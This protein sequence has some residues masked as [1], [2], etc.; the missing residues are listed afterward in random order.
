M[1]TDRRLILPAITLM[2]SALGGCGRGQ[3]RQVFVQ[4]RRGA[5]V[6]VDTGSGVRV[7]APSS[8]VR[9]PRGRSGSAGRVDVPIVEP[10]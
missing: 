7:K 5:Q 10:D 8:A 6:R 3:N 1:M 2:A 9:V 4:D